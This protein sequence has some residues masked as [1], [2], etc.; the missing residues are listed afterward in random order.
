MVSYQGYTENK[1]V[2]LNKFSNFFN[3]I[4][5][6]FFVFHSIELGFEANKKCD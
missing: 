2:E 4:E 5:A 3:S 6:D 1:T